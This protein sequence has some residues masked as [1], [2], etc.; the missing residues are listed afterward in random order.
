MYTINKIKE[1]NSSIQKITLIT[2][3]MNIFFS[4]IIIPAFFYIIIQLINFIFN[5]NYHYIYSQYL[6]IS[7]IC[8]C[9]KYIFGTILKGLKK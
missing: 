9:I 8:I 7:V 5:T 4:C 2:F 3:C 1:L 6:A